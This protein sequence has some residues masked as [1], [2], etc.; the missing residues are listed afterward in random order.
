VL[1]DLGHHVTEADPTYGV[2]GASVLPRSLAGIYDWSRRVPDTQL[3]D[4]RTRHNAGIGR[5]LGG[6]VLALARALEAPMRRQVGGIFRRFDVVLT[7]TTAQPAL[8]VGA[9]DDLGGWQTDRRIVAA[10]PYTWPWNVLGWPGINVPAGVLADESPVGAQLLGPGD[11]E[12]LLI[13][14]AAQLERAVRWQERR[15]PISACGQAETVDG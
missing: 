10:C 12:P 14:L 6:P 1:E 15:P 9:I 13:S 2:F 11:S 4:P 8:P 7:P 3:L 5:L